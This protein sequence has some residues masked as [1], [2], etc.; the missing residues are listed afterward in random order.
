VVY[1]EGG[2][3]GKGGGGGREER[4]K[5]VVSVF[6]VLF[7]FLSTPQCYCYYHAMY[8]CLVRIGLVVGRVVCIVFIRPTIIT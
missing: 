5:A 1:V 4:E 6:T 2:R 8:R 3:E 7:G